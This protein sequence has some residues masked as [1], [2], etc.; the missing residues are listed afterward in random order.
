M[1]AKSEIYPHITLFW[2]I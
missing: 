2:E 1:A